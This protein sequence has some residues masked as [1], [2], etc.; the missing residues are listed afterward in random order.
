MSNVEVCYGLFK[1]LEGELNTFQRELHY[2]ENV[3][4]GINYP[5][6]RIHSSFF[7]ELR[8]STWILHKPE[9]MTSVLTISSNA[10]DDPIISFKA[11]L[12]CHGLVH[13]DFV[14]TLPEIVCKEG[15]HARWIPDICVNIIDQATFK[16]DNTRI[17]SFD[18]LWIK[19][20]INSL[21]A[22]EHKATIDIN[23][24]NVPELQEWNSFLPRYE[25]S[26]PLPWLYNS[27]F[28]NYF[29]LYYCGS[30]NE[31]VHE[32]KYK[33]RLDRLLLAR[34][35][36]TGAIVPIAEAIDMVNGLKFDPDQP[37]MPKNGCVPEMWADYVYFTDME[38]KYNQCVS[39]PPDSYPRRNT[40]YYQ[41]VVAFDSRDDVPTGPNY[42]NI[43]STDPI[44]MLGWVARNT[45]APYAEYYPTYT[46]APYGYS[47][48]K[49]TTLQVDTTVTSKIFEN[50]PAWRTN[51]VYTA[52][53]LSRIPNDKSFNFWFLGATSET[54][55]QQPGI[56]FNN[57]CLSVNIE[58]VDPYHLKEDG[59]YQ[60]QVRGV[61][62]KKFT[63]VDYP[64]TFEDRQ[65]MKTK[66]IIN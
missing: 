4:L 35:I 32:I 31:V 29:P 41:D 60:L 8:K 61:V 54:Q 39:I 24:G 47:P 65:A 26:L 49:D 14:Q 12:E 6:N 51:R 58:N 43:T 10:L 13:S 64:T 20:Y 33:N 63:F 27:S 9:R 34:N 46:M 38:C 48:I 52:K 7:S 1:K 66:I 45:Q 36:E 2:P 44:H 19:M 11:A 62:A 59:K 17:Q 30:L 18:T 28:S 57:G 15:Y 23:I 55:D 5:G 37:L 16:F 42:V 40:V 53:H 22:Q 56:L 50:L 21:I 3:S 25:C